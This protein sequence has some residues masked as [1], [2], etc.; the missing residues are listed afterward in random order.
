MDNFKLGLNQL[1]VGFVFDVCLGFSL[2]FIPG[3][4]V[5]ST[6]KRCS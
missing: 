3:A 1:W 2:F 6:V 4:I 5:L